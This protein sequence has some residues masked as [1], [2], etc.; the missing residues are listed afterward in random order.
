MSSISSALRHATVLLPALLVLVV[1]GNDGGEE[2][3]RLMALYRRADSLY[4]LAHST[5]ATDSLALAGFGAVIQAYRSL[6]G[7][8]E[9]D[10]LLAGALLRKGVLLDAAGDYSGAKACYIG[11]LNANPREDSLSFVAE[12]DMGAIYYNLNHFDSAN[13]FLLKAQTL[14]HAYNDHDDEVRLYNTLGVLYFDNGNYREA[15]DFFDKALGIVKAKKP[16]DIDFM[17]SLKSNIATASFL[18]GQYQDALDT[19]RQLLSYRMLTNHVNMSMG[20]AYEGL[21]DYPAALACFYRVN[22]QEIPGVLNELAYSQEQLH[23]ADSCNWYLDALQK[24]AAEKP[25]QVNPMDLGINAL[26]RS[27][28]LSDQG[29]YMPALT[30]LQKAIVMFSRNFKDTAIH[31][32]PSNFMGTIAGYRLFDALV[33]KAGLFRQ[34]YRSRSDKDQ[35]RACYS[36]YTAALSLLRYIEKSYATD[37]SKLFLKKQSGPVHAAALAVCLRLDSLYPDSGYMEQAFL[38]SERSKASVIMA[39]LQEKAFT[40]SG[41]GRR[42][43][44][45]VNDYKYNIARLNVKSESATDSAELAA[46]TR[47]KEGD[48]LELSR[49]EHAM[50]QNGAYNE[51]KYGDASPGI[52]ELQQELGRG[53]A[54]ISLY[55]TDSVLHVWVVTRK[56][57]SYLPIDSVAA[58]RA[59]VESWLDALK[60]TGNGHRFH[61]DVFGARIYS[62]LIRPIQRVADASEWI[63]VPDGFLYLLP[64][65]SLPADGAGDKRLVETTTISY[66]WSSRLLKRS[67]AVQGAKILAFAP[68]AKAGADGAD[69][70]FSRLPASAE[71]IAGLPGMRYFDAQ[72]T[73]ARFLHT[74]GQYSI[75][76]LATHAVSSPDNAAASYIA[77]FP[78]KHSPIEDRLYLEELYGLD[79]AGTR[80]VIISA[81]ETGEGKVIAQEGVISL[82]RAFAY[83]GCGSTINSLWKADD[84]ATSYILRR[85]YVYLRQGETQARALQLAKLDYLKSDA[86]DKSPAFWAHL[87]LTGDSGA[88]YEKS[89]WA[90]W[91]WAILILAGMTISGA[92]V[93]RRRKKKSTV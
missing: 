15:R 44:Q 61:G 3:S 71:E 30:A 29:R 11:A 70:P 57:F 55:A 31:A 16:V 91:R 76:H 87:V 42:L 43:Q 59:D 74:V 14:V 5:P 56:A 28:W 45:Q 48:E 23:R 26:Y 13:Y 93:W 54:L 34:L 22:R 79:L 62:R 64:W 89:F 82:A 67:G 18:L 92:L 12:V 66:R 1:L 51:L 90:K 10:T 35:L 25:G 50:E 46:I 84:Q 8:A 7:H 32:N 36:A 39:N 17:V 60:A 53:Q 4:H 20:N 65:E 6:P 58:L 41:A 75:V 52:R 68:F 80:L 9:K 88:L 2:R 27:R 49:L 77:F 47:E 81:C 40:G 21:H 83:A 38:I 78:L 72:A 19:Y 69:G 63:I 85:F 86:I 37:E 73:K 24:M 33:Q